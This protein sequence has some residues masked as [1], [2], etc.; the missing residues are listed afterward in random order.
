MDELQVVE[1]ANQRILTTQQIAESY[2]TDTAIISNNFNRNKERYTE[3]K[4]YYCPEGTELKTFKTNHQ[5]DDSSIR[6]NKLYLWTERGALL[7]A[8][9]LNT[10]KAW[11]VYDHL[12]ENYFKKADKIPQTLPEALRLAADL[13]E[14]NAEL[15]AETDKQAQL[16]GELKP[17]ADYVDYILSSRGTL[18]ISQIA[19][20]YGISANKLNKILQEERI[21][22]KINDRWILYADHMNNGYT[23][24]ET[25][26]FKRSDGTP[27]IKLFTK[28]TQRGRLMI[29]EILN[30]RGI[31]ANM[32]LIQSA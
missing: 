22:R 8:K 7:H 27:D 4:H 6:V 12:V 13:A 29:N 26:D 16:I 2:E 21:Q 18:T 20:D 15:R 32:D 10:D 19:A 3:G 30:K 25:I 11:E 9:S 1:Y 31:Y 28:W 24:S 5:F 23:K 17:K 14:K